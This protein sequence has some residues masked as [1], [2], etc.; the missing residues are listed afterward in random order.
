M[1]FR[2]AKKEKTEAELHEEI[3]EDALKDASHPKKSSRYQRILAVI[4]G[5]LLMSLML[6]YLLPAGT[7]AILTASLHTYVI[8]GNAIALGN[9]RKI[10]FLAG[11]YEEVLSRYYANQKTETKMCLLGA[12]KGNSYEVSALVFPEIFSQG[13][14]HVSARPCSLGTIIDLHTHPYKSCYFSPQD[15]LT[16]ESIRERDPDALIGV[17][18][19]NGRFN[20]YGFS[21]ES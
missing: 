7:L 21:Q 18:C 10:I 6:I 13:F 19:E 5:L 1:D 12:K 4:A 17:M 2:M 20:L 15:L 16:Y 3:L 8:E 11:V 9:G 14:S